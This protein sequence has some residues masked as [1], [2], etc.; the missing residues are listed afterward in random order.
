MFRGHTQ[1]LAALTL[2]A[3][4]G[5]PYTFEEAVE[6]T[7]TRELDDDELDAVAGGSWCFII[8][9][10]HDSGSNTVDTEDGVGVTGFGTC[11]YVGIGLVSY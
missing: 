10:G 4:V 9:G 8:G 1:Y 11:D 2:A 5:L 3:E 7:Q 6:S